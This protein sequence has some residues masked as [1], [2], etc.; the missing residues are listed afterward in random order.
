M[1]ARRS[2]AATRAA[3]HGVNSHAS[4][5]AAVGDNCKNIF[6][7]ITVLER[8]HQINM[9]VRKTSLWDGVGLGPGVCGGGSCPAGRP[10]TRGPRR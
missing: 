2:A 5:E 1:R 8:A 3:R 9:K 7:I 10:D 4:L 6:K